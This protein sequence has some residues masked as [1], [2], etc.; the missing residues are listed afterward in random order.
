MRIPSDVR[1][2]V[3]AQLWEQADRL[4][5]DSIGSAEKAR[6]YR[7]WT[8]SL[9]IGGALSAYMDPRSVRVYIKDTLLKGY[10][11]QKLNQH[12]ALM[13]RLVG[14]D[15]SEIVED[16]IKPHGL[17]FSDGTL[18][19]WGRADDWKALLGTLFDRGFETGGPTMVA[20]SR[21]TAFRQCLIT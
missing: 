5:W 14:Q 21:L 17:R 12:Q 15:Q 6:H 10:S 3:R 9:A 1:S 8:D 18:V 2:R 13:L 7:Q 16:F 11:R 4:D 19:A 20:F